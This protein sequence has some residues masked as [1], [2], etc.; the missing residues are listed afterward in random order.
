GAGAALAALAAALAAVRRLEGPERPAAAA[1]AVAV[2]AYVLHALVDIDW[3]FVA[4]SAPLF[5]VLGVLV[6]ASSATR[7]PA[8]R[9]LWALGCA[10]L[11]FA[12]GYSLTAPGSSAAESHS[13]GRRTTSTR[14]RSTR[15]GRGRRPSTSPAAIARR[16]GST[17]AP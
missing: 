15:S 1:L 6:G 3:E 10:V 16:S 5:L 9:P 7:Q 4:V 2:P 11:V 12:A 17:G 14:S 13:R 8:R